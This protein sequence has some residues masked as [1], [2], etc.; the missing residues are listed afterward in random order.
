MAEVGGV[1][2]CQI[3]Q[4]AEIVIPVLFHSETPLVR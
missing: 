2:V 1:E 4:N 3:F